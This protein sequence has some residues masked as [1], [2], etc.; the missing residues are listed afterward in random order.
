MLKTSGK[1]DY[2]IYI[3]LILLL[4]ANVIYFYFL[5]NNKLKEKSYIEEQALD[6]YANTIEIAVVN[7]LKQIFVD[8]KSDFTF[9]D[10]QKSCKS[11]K[12]QISVTYSSLQI[13][14]DQQCKLV[15]ISKIRNLINKISSTEYVYHISLNEVSLLSNTDDRDISRYAKEISLHEGYKATLRVDFDNNSNLK[16]EL[17][18]QIHQS[19]RLNI[20]YSVI[21]ILI[22]IG[23]V[24]LY[25]REKERATKAF[26][27]KEQTKKYINKEKNFIISCYK[28]SQGNNKKAH[29]VE[30]EYFPIPV[31][32]KTDES[33]T[34]IT[35]SKKLK[36]IEKY[37][38]SYI[39][40]RES[41]N[42]KIIYSCKKNDI[43]SVPFSEVVLNQ[44]LISII[45]NL[46]NFSE[47]SEDK[48]LIKIDF[49]NTIFSFETNG[50]QLNK[51]V[52]IM[53]SQRIFY[54]SYNP[55]I[56]NFH[57]IIGIL[58]KHR[59]KIDIVSETNSKII[60]NFKRK[61][62]EKGGSETQIIHLQSYKRGTK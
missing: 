37:F 15:D 41:K 30:E 23:I 53:A 58:T 6:N 1:Q 8:F 17:L 51:E 25:L 48:K 56:L 38:E 52:A 14:Y 34:T 36:E 31:I 18:N 61:E 59:V 13:S 5:Y 57:Q 35:P 40:H 10:N 60:L 47:K 39:N 19:I 26:T 24:L 9:I 20:F 46:L 4:L 44:I 12:Q 16:R 33:I 11:I 62:K 50:F 7:E 55:Y 42:I 21:I 29:S 49:T 54:D 45:F 43:V 3:L 2:K 27:S 28:F 32:H 22:V